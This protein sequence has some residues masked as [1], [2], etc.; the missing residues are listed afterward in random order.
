MVSLNLQTDSSNCP[1]ADDD[2]DDDDDFAM[3]PLSGTFLSCLE[4][5]ICILKILLHAVTMKWVVRNRKTNV[6]YV[7]WVACAWPK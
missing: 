4:F 6:S 1:R 3:S 2:D 7:T 5:K